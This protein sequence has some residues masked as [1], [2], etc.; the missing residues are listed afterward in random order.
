MQAGR[1][2]DKQAEAA[3]GRQAGRS[4]RQAGRQAGRQRQAGAPDPSSAPPRDRLTTRPDWKADRLYQSVPLNCSLVID[5]RAPLVAPMSYL[6]AGRRAGRQARGAI[7][8]G[9]K[10]EVGQGVG[11]C[12]E[13]C[14]LANN[15]IN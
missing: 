9:K 2:R 11:S 13:R 7:K 3:A 5:T 1:D 15:T 4:R 12:S 8:Q 14:L 6:Q 10:Q